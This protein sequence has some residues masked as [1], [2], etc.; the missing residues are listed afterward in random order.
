MTHA[1]IEP[2]TITEY[3]NVQTQTFHETQTIPTKPKTTTSTAT[4]TTDLSHETTIS[5]ETQTISTTPISTT[6]TAT[7]A[8]S[9]RCNTVIQKSTPS[10]QCSRLVE[11]DPRREQKNSDPNIPGWE[12]MTCEE[13]CRICA[14]SSDESDAE[15]IDPD[16]EMQPLP[17]DARD[18]MK[19]ARVEVWPQATCGRNITTLTWARLPT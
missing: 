2:Q 18:W 10:T 7:Q 12:P 1:T 6:S 8:A 13:V 3:L 5:V 19:G 14:D 15:N 17:W 16:D 11:P 4:Q 9:A